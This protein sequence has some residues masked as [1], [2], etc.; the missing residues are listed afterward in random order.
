LPPIAARPAFRNKRKPIPFRSIGRIAPER[1]QQIETI[2]RRPETPP[3]QRRRKDQMNGGMMIPE[4]IGLSGPPASERV[5]DAVSYL[6]GGMLV[7]GIG[8]MAYGAALY[9]WLSEQIDS[10]AVLIKAAGP[11]LS[12]TPKA[13]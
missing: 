11:T 9:C 2:W 13:V 8:A 12:R 6:A 7:A 5:K 10:A 4:L 3:A 1:P